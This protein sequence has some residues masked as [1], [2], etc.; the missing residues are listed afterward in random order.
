MSQTISDY[1]FKVDD[2]EF[3]PVS[4]SS[5]ENILKKTKADWYAGPTLVESLVK[6]SNLILNL[7]SVDRSLEI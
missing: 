1:G 4:A 7:N 6:K 3:I 5:G 2:I